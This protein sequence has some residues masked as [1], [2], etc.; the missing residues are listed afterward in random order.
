MISGG[1][2]P[3]DAVSVAETGQPGLKRCMEF[4]EYTDKY[5]MGDASSAVHDALKMVCPPAR[6][7]R[8][9]VMAQL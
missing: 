2:I 6:T 8:S 4:M 7:M 1:V 5:G 9:M 3:T